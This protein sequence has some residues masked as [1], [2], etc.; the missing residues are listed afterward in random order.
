[1]SSLLRIMLNL[2]YMADFKYVSNDAI[3]SS[4]ATN[5][6]VSNCISYCCCHAC[7][8]YYL[9]NNYN[10]RQGELAFSGVERVIRCLYLASKGGSSFC[11]VWRLIEI[12][13][14]IGIIH[15]KYFLFWDLSWLWIWFKLMGGYSYMCEHA[16]TTYMWSLNMWTY[17]LKHN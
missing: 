4:S 11:S 16:D 13:Y 9:V 5:A 3:T 1:M 17:T 2:F 15:I 8:S 6:G 7:W 10:S 14:F 12:F